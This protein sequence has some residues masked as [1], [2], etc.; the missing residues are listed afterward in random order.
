MRCLQ[1]L[2]RLDGFILVENK[3]MV[4]HIPR[5]SRISLHEKK[6]NISFSILELNIL[7]HDFLNVPKPIDKF[8]LFILFFAHIYT[9]RVYVNH[10]LSE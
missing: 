5:Y 6:L 10:A 3:P 2:L 4:I 8:M 7:L 1:T 9:K